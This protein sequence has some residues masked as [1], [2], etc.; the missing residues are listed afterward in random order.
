MKSQY[1][2]E[3][4]VLEYLGNLQGRFLELGAFDGVTGSNTYCLLERG[5]KGVLVE[6]SPT[7]FVKLLNNMKGFSSA[8][9]VNCAISDRFGVTEFFENGQ[10]ST[11][12]PSEPSESAPDIN[13]MPDGKKFYVATCTIDHLFSFF[14]RDFD[15]IDIDIELSSS[16]VLKSLPVASMDKLKMICVEKWKGWERSCDD[17]FSEFKVIADTPANLFYFRT[18]ALSSMKCK[19]N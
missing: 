2:E 13:I 9:C 1:N 11:I 12:I 3:S 4:I 18:T 16:L 5:W 7:F 10:T 14:G 15:F 8:E 17:K 19:L 6:P